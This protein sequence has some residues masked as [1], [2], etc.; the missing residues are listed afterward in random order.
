MKSYEGKQPLYF[1]TPSPQLIHALHTALHQLLLSSPSNLPSPESSVKALAAR[2]EAHSAASD[3][4]KAHMTDKLGLQQLATRPECAAHGMT[5]FWLPDGVEGPPLL[6][7]LS[8][9]GVVFAAGLHKE[10]KAKYARLGHMGVSV[11][12][13]GRGDI[14]KALKALEESLAE[15]GYK[16]EQAAS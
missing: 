5:A 6:K 1:A 15:L 8:E 10:I 13:K 16:P 11:M 9:K 3:R 14:D 4:I 2:F 7:K 12:D